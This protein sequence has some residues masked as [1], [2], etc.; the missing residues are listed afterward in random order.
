MINSE[1]SNLELLIGEHRAIAP[2]YEFTIY[3]DIALDETFLDFYEQSMQ[4]LKGQVTHY[5]A[6]SMKRPAVIDK[7]ALQLLPTWIKRPRL[8]KSYYA[9]F[10]GSDRS[11]GTTAASILF[12]L[13]ARPNPDQ[14]S[15]EQKSA[16]QKSLQHYYNNDLMYS[17][18]PVNT[19]RVTLPLDHE[20]A[21]G[22]AFKEWVLGFSALSR[23]QFA[24]GH[25]GL[26]LNFDNSVV[27]SDIREIMTG[28]LA[29]LLL[30]HPGLDWEN[31]GSVSNFLLSWKKEL[32]DFIPQIKRVQWLTFLSEK[33]LQ[34][35]GCQKKL[36]ELLGNDLPITIDP[37]RHGLSIQAGKE[38][39]LGDISRRDFLP[40]YRRVAA[41]LRPVRLS[42]HQ[43]V[44]RG[45]SDEAAQEWLEGLDREY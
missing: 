30:R 7:K 36:E 2:C 27:S 44:G 1:L 3:S 4:A 43:G 18:P 17:S 20:L 21:N 40:V 38:P 14:I 10:L 25:A 39:E 23:G 6:E 13:H 19:L 35:L 32:S 5:I 8:G 28:R 29:A 42:K 33:T 31:T 24:S 16:H 26:S 41:A 15:A 37:L 9:E 11:Y 34:Y 45:F 12:V 22:A